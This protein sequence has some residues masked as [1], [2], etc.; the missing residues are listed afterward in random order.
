MIAAPAPAT[1]WPAITTTSTGATAAI[2]E[3]AAKSTVPSSSTLRAPSP[4]ASAPAGSSRL[5][6]AMA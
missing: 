4:S 1:T 2:A 6:N 5:A 3:P